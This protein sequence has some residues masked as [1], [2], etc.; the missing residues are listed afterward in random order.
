MVGIHLVIII[1][2]TSEESQYNLLNEIDTSPSWML[3]MVYTPVQQMVLMCAL[4]TSVEQYNYYELERNLSILDTIGTA[5]SVPLKRCLY[6]R[7]KFV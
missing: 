6:S 1:I 5:Q 7:G 3:D 2:I 4:Q